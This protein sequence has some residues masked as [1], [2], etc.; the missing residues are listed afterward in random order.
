MK[1]LKIINHELIEFI[2]EYQENPF[3]YLYESDIQGKLFASFFDALRQNQHYITL[4]V[5]LHGEEHFFGKNHINILPVKTEY[6]AGICFD[7]AFIDKDRLQG[8]EEIK[9]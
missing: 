9:K 8:C 2:K 6:P 7:I 1:I 3:N 5:E 4:N